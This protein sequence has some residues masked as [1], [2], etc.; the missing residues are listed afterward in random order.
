VQPWRLPSIRLDVH[1]S[2]WR[3]EEHVGAA[4]RAGC[5]EVRIAKYAIT[6]VC[7]DDQARHA[8]GTLL[9]R[10]HDAVEEFCTGLGLGAA[11]DRKPASF[12]YCP[13]EVIQYTMQ[14][15][16]SSDHHHA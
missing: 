10:N 11:L 2:G 8:V 14:Q 13:L 12:H 7:T 15:F 5:E 9:T 1:P 6:K 4:L 16:L 3:G